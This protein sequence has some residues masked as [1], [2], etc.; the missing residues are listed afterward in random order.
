MSWPKSN[1]ASFTK[2]WA[3]ELPDDDFLHEIV[4]RWRAQSHNPESLGYE[5]PQA[6]AVAHQIMQP[7]QQAAG[8]PGASAQPSIRRTV[9]PPAPAGTGAPAFGQTPPLRTAAPPP[10]AAP[11]APNPGQ[12]QSLASLIRQFRG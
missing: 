11:A 5:M 7:Q 1:T 3:K 2:S 12:Q 4:I 8:Q 6:V 10:P 9:P